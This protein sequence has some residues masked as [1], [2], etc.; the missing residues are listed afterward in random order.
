MDRFLAASIHDYLEL[1]GRPAATLSASEYLEFASAFRQLCTC[2]L[3][4][5]VVSSGVSCDSQQN[6]FH[7]SQQ[8]VPHDSKP[9]D[10]DSDIM[11]NPR[12]T[13]E[14][15]RI[16]GARIIIKSNEVNSRDETDNHDVMRSHAR[17]NG[18]APENTVGRKT[19]ED[20]KR[21]TIINMMKS[22]E[23]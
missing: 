16:P 20:R 4:Q 3:M 15:E 19:I 14:H 22:I 18:T 17:S 9:N 6:T 23:C 5:S 21:S 13:S 12:P 2:N 11:R 8:S 1:T 7:D 10:E